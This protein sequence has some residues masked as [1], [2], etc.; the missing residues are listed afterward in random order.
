[1]NKKYPR[2]GTQ[3]FF[4]KIACAET[5]EPRMMVPYTTEEARLTLGGSGVKPGGG[6][7]EV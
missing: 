7:V 2:V 4:E 5:A 6:A 3:I 1:M